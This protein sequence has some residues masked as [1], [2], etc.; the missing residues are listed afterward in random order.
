[1]PKRAKTTCP[2]PGCPELTDGGRCDEHKSQAEQQRGSGKDRGWTPRWARFRKR[3]LDDNPNCLDCLEGDPPQ[4]TPATD[5]DH[6][7]GTG[8][9]GP[10]AY[11][12]DNLRPLCHSCHSRKTVTFDGGFGR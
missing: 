12:L 6:V 2:V 7:D 4:W 1:M 5:I 3:Y 10:H 9:N 8:R 11:D